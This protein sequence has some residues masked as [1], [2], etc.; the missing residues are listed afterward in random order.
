[1][2]KSLFS[3]WMPVGKRLWLLWRFGFLTPSIMED[4]RSIPTSESILEKVP[5]NAKSP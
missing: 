2:E 4:W 5:K 3:T 1:M